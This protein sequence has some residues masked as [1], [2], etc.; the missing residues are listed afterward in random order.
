MF[1]MCCLFVPPCIRYD[2]LSLRPA[3]YMARCLFCFLQTF[4]LTSTSVPWSAWGCLLFR[5]TSLLGA[6]LSS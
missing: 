5:V 1:T 2:V 4:L 3:V 6:G